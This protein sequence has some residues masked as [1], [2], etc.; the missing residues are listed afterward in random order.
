MK[1]IFSYLLLTLFYQPGFSQ[2]LQ[3][4]SFTTRDGLSN[5]LVTAIIRDDRQLLWL[6]TPFGIDWF[7]GKRFY[8]PYIPAKTGQLYVTDFYRDTYGAIWTLTFYNGLYKYI[9]GRFKSFLP[10]T[11]LLTSNSN[12][13]FCMLQYDKGHYIVGTDYN[14]FWFDGEAFKLFDSTNPSLGLQIHCLLKPNDSTVLVGTTEG[15]WKY[16]LKKSGKKQRSL[17]LN[18]H[19]ISSMLSQ[20]NKLWV[21]TNKGLFAYPKQSGISEY[22]LQLYLPSLPVYSVT[23]GRDNSIWFTSDKTYLL[24][25]GILTGFDKS[26]G[27]PASIT[28]AYFDHYGSSWF[29]SS[30][31]FAKLGDDIFREYNLRKSGVH[32]MIISLQ[33]DTNALWL[34]SYAGLLKKRGNHFEKINTI[35]G[36]ELGYIAWIL[37]RRNGRLLAGTQAGIVNIK[38]DKIEIL[39]KLVTTKAFEDNLGNVW[40]GTV[41]GR[42]FSLKD[43]TLQE[44]QFTDPHRDYIDGIYK[45]NDARLWL[46]YR[47]SGVRI[48]TIQGFKGTLAKVFDGSNGFAD[49]R[50]RCATTD[51]KGNVI[52]GTRT[53]GLFIFSPSENKHWHINTSAGLSA[54]W[55]KTVSADENNNLYVATNKGADIITNGFDTPV[56]R[57]LRVS[58]DDNISPTNTVLI[59]Y[60]TVWVGT[61]SGLIA[62]YPK[63]YKVD[64]SE[65]KVF[66]TQLSVNG[67]NVPGFIQFST[68]NEPLTLT[69]NENVIA[70]G[71]AGI[72]FSS[73]HVKYSYILEGQ[74]NSW[75]PPSE[76]NF[77]SYNLPPG[78][79]VFKVRAINT[80]GVTSRTAASLS[81]TIAPP[82]WKTSWFLLA[83]LIVAVAA[84]YSFYRYRLSQ[85]LK[86]E[87][88]RS[89]ISADLHDELGSGLSRIKFL[90][91]TVKRSGMVSASVEKDINKIAF[92]SDEMS[93]R[94]GEIVWALNKKNDLLAELISYIRSY[95][96]EYITGQGM[97]CI[98]NIPANLPDVQVDGETRSNIF[99]SLK[100]TLNNI[101]RHAGASEVQLDISI[102]SNSLVIMI[103]DNGKGIDWNNI[104]K[105][106]NGLNNIRERM[107][108]S[109]GTASFK[110]DHGTSVIFT[111]PLKT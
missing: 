57:K 61:D 31:G 53:N 26:D 86:I 103:R 43:T 104:R 93:A 36:K 56:I 11:T 24:K 85:V 71:F 70:F 16:I 12:N 27:L 110:T 91:E 19:R 60:D 51:K 38:Y 9:N 7:D 5:N 42:L 101:V 90:S 94:I 68:E 54:N 2:A 92:Y 29:I 78:K 50:I 55:V 4:K 95:T 84:L 8:E 65:Q 62:Y 28:K 108:N 107:K 76:R 80:D 20:G 32:S 25:N 73:Q 100:E 77:V 69:H 79:Y 35:A 39:N 87:K 105:F 13:V 97:A 40:L 89:R 98:A 48:F 6:G 81:F 67:K 34:G 3:L 49:L 22:P 88:M 75:S 45:D 82:F 109:K 44:I 66:L 64:V 21:A 99:L 46:G 37:R 106:S 83:C 72:N 41:D 47:S 74:D 23:E 111:I 10:D 18:G 30:N 58:T 59:Q 17:F 52:F 14:V 63:K 1:K 96:M 33:Y 102:K 15:L